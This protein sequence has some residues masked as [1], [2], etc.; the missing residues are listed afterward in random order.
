MATIYRPCY[1][2]RTEVMDALDVKLG[3]YAAPRVDR[4][5]QSGADAVDKLCQR[6]FYFEDKTVTWDWPNYQY[7]YPWRVWFDEAELADV[8]VNVPVVNSGGV[9][10]S[11]SDIFWGDP[12]APT[13]PYTYLE[14]NRSTSAYFGNGPTPQREIS[15]TGTYGYGITTSAA[16]QLAA[17]CASSDA[18]ITVSQGN[19]PGVGDVL[20]VDS[21]RMLVTDQSFV[22]T[23][24]TPSSGCTTAKP[25]DNILAVPSGAAFTQGEVI[26]LDYEWMLV[27]MIMGNNLV[28]KRAWGGSILNDHSL[29]AIW[30]QRELSVLR[31]VLGTTAASH[32]DDAPVVINQPPGLIKQL[33]IAEAILSLTNEPQAYA[34]VSGT[35]TAGSGV[36]GT[37]RTR[38][39]EP[40]VGVGII[41]LRQQVA[42]IY[43]RESRSGVV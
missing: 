41:G 14:L 39:R 17:S 12:Q 22:D 32:S 27:Q 11:N 40:Q 21:E 38:A 20:I 16:G 19:T 13:A 3:A 7:A 8:T 26:L 35:V 34:S 18:T 31:G 15:I 42:S 28:V 2:T 1:A 5:I 9:I 6:K 4:A 33:N 36:G 43:A 37:G 10:I 25:N 29:P 24:I 23:S 30:A